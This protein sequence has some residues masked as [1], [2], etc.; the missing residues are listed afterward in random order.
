MR[1]PRLLNSVGARSDFRQ[2]V[3]VSGNRVSGHGVSAHGVSG[4][5]VEAP[6][7]AR[8]VASLCWI[9][10]VRRHAATHRRLGLSR[11]VPLDPRRRGNAP[12]GFREW[13]A[14]RRDAS[15]A[16]VCG[17]SSAT[18]T[19]VSRPSSVVSSQRSSSADRRSS[20]PTRLPAAGRS[21][22]ASRASR[23]SSLAPSASPPPPSS[24]AASR[25]RAAFPSPDRR[26]P[27]RGTRRTSSR[28]LSC[29]WGRVSHPPPA[30]SPARSGT[31]PQP[32][33]CSWLPSRDDNCL[34][35][36]RGVAS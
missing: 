18:S 35:E 14:C 32:V 7:G 24:A 25:A 6:R 8:T 12:G 20:P 26:A 36:R 27:S 3:D 9:V 17:S 11:R 10:G 13:Q 2:R 31:S 21:H 22:P 33:A 16:C 5:V 23:R 30:P 15:W 4:C 29:P 1:K 34:V 28:R 19:A